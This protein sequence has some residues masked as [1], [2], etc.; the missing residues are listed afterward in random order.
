MFTIISKLTD[1]KYRGAYLEIEPDKANNN[2]FLLEKEKYW[3]GITIKTDTNFLPEWQTIRKN[4]LSFTDYIRN[5]NYPI[6][7]QDVKSISDDPTLNIA[8]FLDIPVYILEDIPLEEENL[9]FKII[10]LR[11]DKGG[12]DIKNYHKLASFEGDETLWVNQ[13]IYKNFSYL[14]TDTVTTPQEFSYKIKP[15][16]IAKLSGNDIV[17]LKKYL[18]KA[19]EKNMFLDSEKFDMILLKTKIT[20]IMTKMIEDKDK[21]QE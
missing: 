16:E 7:F 15:R 10:L 3:R 5:I 19:F 14:K 12:N 6:L 2:T 18:T 1:Q 20:H 8:E 13:E 9:T 4:I 21:S 17:F 11:G